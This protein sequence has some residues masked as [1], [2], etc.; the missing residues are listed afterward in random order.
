M[1]IFGSAQKNTMQMFPHLQMFC[2]RSIRLE[3]LNF[4]NKYY[5]FAVK[6]LV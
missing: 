6:T 2:D 4:S 5:L 3:I 1:E